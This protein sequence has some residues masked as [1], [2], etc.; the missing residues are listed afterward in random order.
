MN[1]AE[2]ALNIVE[3]V[4]IECKQA[5]GKDGNGEVPHDFW[6]TYSAMANTYGGKV[7]LGIKEKKGAF[8]AVGIKNVEKV[9][10]DLFNTLNN[11]RK[12]S[13]NLLDDSHVYVEELDEKNIL[14]IEV[15]QAE[16]KQRP[17]Y[18][19]GNPL[20]GTYV[21]LH[22]G[23]IKCSET[24]VKNML[25]EQSRDTLDDQIHHGF[26]IDDIDTKTLSAYRTSLARLK[27]NHIW[28]EYD[29]LSL[30]KALNGWRKDRKTGD[31]GLTTAGLLM[32]GKWTSIQEAL[33]NYFIEYQEQ[34]DSST[35]WIDRIVPDG[36]W[37]GNIFDFYRKVYS[38]LTEDLKI[39]FSL[40]K[41][42]YRT[43]ESPIHE[44]LREALVNT[45][46]HANYSGQAPIKIIKR[47]GLFY[48]RNPGNI[49]IPLSTAKSGGLSDCRNKYL[50]QMFLMA[51]LG[52]R[53]GSGLPKIFSGWK[54]Q[55]WSEPQLK[56]EREQDITTLELY[57]ETMIPQNVLDKV[58][59]ICGEK[60]SK[61]DR[62][63]IFIVSE[64]I[65]NEIISHESLRKKTSA[66]SRSITL[67]L[68]KLVRLKILN[69]DGTP[70][71]KRYFS[72]IHSL[73]TPD[74]E[75]G[76]ARRK[77]FFN[78]PKSI[79]NDLEE[80]SDRPISPDGSPIQ[81]QAFYD[82]FIN[83][84]YLES[85]IKSFMSVI[86]DRVKIEEAN[87]EKL[88]CERDDPNNS[89]NIESINIKIAELEN[90]LEKIKK[91]DLQS[92]LE[93]KFT[94]A[95][96]KIKT[97]YEFIKNEMFV[98]ELPNPTGTIS[99]LSEAKELLKEF[100]WAELMEISKPIREAN[101]RKLKKSQTMSMILLLSMRSFLTVR[102]LSN[103]LGRHP[104]SL[105]RDFLAPLIKDGLLRLAYPTSPTHSDQG[106][107]TEQP[108]LFE[109]PFDLTKY[110]E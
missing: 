104:K 22:E 40:D 93:K 59:Q 38:K 25:A 3:G 92:T 91:D 50:H 34:D 43:E 88:L 11:K 90:F 72:P 78:L 9:K 101:K 30:I 106:Y 99:M 74:N 65:T 89:H 26:T 77:T 17:V 36:S 67:S 41:D 85:Y 75:K 10:T 97:F 6:E 8:F 56:E 7:Y 19:N 55:Y 52:E 82:L 66:E 54:S 95:D 47:N 14:V 33:P 84:H 53:A 51:G 60:I 32:F 98:F 110:D 49:R 13:I 107:R 29:D 76:I 62:L 5:Q 2:K 86:N 24:E 103:L 58:H 96:G 73:V 83:D 27:P 35:R 39:P 100:R 21:R 69:S 31:E 15:P 45:L 12:V 23:D 4:N 28:L 68:A 80:K 64:S 109:Y 1:T 57:T 44:A 102:D 16:T 63:D 108:M 37:S 46:V 42:G 70:R 94:N 81:R 61:L 20:T 48:F 79:I 105:R 71:N 87:L 18:L